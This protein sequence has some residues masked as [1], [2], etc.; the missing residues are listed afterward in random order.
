M[1]SPRD[2]T[3]P[4]HAFSLWTSASKRS[5]RVNHCS[6][7]QQQAQL[8]YRLDDLKH[9]HE[10]DTTTYSVLRGVQLAREPWQ[11][12]MGCNHCQSQAGAEQK[13]VFLLFAVSIRTLLSLLQK[14]NIS[15]VGVLVGSFELSVDFKAK[16][17]DQLSREALQS[18]TTALQY[19]QKHAGR[20]RHATAAVLGSSYS[21]WEQAGG[22]ILGAPTE[23]RRQFGHQPAPL[24]LGADSVA[25]L[26]DML[27][28][29][30]QA[31]GQAL[32]A[33]S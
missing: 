32:K 11:N 18:I 7:L 26:L 24:I 6:C 12:L 27:Q 13:E 31:M 19:L 33:L 30:M 4:G 2:L 25:S 29:K 17:M 5:S 3:S 23:P 28:S 16:V 8:A 10:H 20:P 14:P 9:T 15:S 22:M 21:T 1:F